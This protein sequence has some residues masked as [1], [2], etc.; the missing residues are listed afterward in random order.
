VSEFDDKLLQSIGSTFRSV[1]ALELLLLLRSDHRPWSTSELVARLRASELVVTNALSGLIAAGLTSL[2]AQGAI[3]QPANDETKNFVDRV[4]RLYASRP[5]AVR[6]AIVAS[7][8]SGA[9]AF[10]N[11]FRLRK[12]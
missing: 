11:A 8:A 3:Y 4:E 5:D 7:S 1:W 10:A 12:D 6:R 2:D 9:A